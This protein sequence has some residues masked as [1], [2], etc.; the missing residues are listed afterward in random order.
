[1]ALVTHDD[2]QVLGIVTLYDV[3]EGIVGRLPE[4]REAMVPGIVVRGDGSRLVDGLL[5]F[6]EFLE[7]F[8]K[9]VSEP[10][11]FATLHEFV[12]DA[13][14]GSPSL[15]SVV[16]WSGL[17]LEVVDMDGSRVDKV[18]VQREEGGGRP[19]DTSQA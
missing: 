12:V 11:R 3:L 7:A 6:R 2:G 19:N 14:D 1:M 15:A 5:P 13:L 10:R 18:L 4:I 16:R 17:E 8:D 9:E